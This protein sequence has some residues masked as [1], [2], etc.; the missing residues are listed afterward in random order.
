MIGLLSAKPDLYSSRRFIEAFR[1]KLK[2]IHP[3]EQFSKRRSKEIDFLIP[4]YSTYYIEEGLNFHRQMSLCG[5]RSL[6]SADAFSTFSD[7][8]L[9]FLFLREKNINTVPSFLEYADFVSAYPEARSF[10]LKKRRG[11]KGSGVYHCS[12]ESIGQIDAHDKSYIFQPFIE[13]AKGEDIRILVLNGRCLG[14]IKRISRE[15]EFRS[16]YCI[17]GLIEPY[18]PD[19]NMISLLN[20]FNVHLPQGFYGIDIIQTINGP[21]ILEVNTCP[22]F[23]AFEK[24]HGLVVTEAICD[25]INR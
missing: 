15:G 12:H 5:I 10:I 6:T 16:N 14:A 9:G 1:G 21:A 24:I 25:F 23:E 19:F 4:R 20:G 11:S 7:K 18:E 2:V 8:W 22:G 17:N 13:E 3:A